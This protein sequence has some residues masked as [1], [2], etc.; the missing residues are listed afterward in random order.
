[1]LRAWALSLLT[2]AVDGVE[3]CAFGQG[4]RGCAGRKDDIL[5]LCLIKLVL[6]ARLKDETDHQRDNGRFGRLT[7]RH[8]GT[9]PGDLGRD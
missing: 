8:R 4:A 2:L 9:E 7:N 6:A 3:L 1:M 5:R